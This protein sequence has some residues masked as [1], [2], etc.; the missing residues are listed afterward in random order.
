MLFHAVVVTDAE[1]GADHCQ[2]YG[3]TILVPKL[4]GRKCH[5]VSTFPKGNFLPFFCYLEHNC[6]FSIVFCIF[7]Q[8]TFH[9]AY[10]LTG[11]RESLDLPVLNC[12][13]G[14]HLQ[15]GED[16]KKM[17]DFE[18]RDNIMLEGIDCIGY[19]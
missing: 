7:L 16:G 13:V 3:I 15:D 12:S 10:S 6:I 18:E 14:S 8:G 19:F 4:C 9:F 11:S 5:P 1:A 17:N 2:I